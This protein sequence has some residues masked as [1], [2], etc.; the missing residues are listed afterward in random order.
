M[1][2]FG[3][4][5]DTRAVQE[6]PGHRDVKTTMIYTHVL[7]RGPAGLRS[8]RIFCETAGPLMRIN[9]RPRAK[10]MTVAMAF[11]NKES[12]QHVGPKSGACYIVQGL[13]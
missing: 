4:G 1:R 11:E 8:P 12:S 6:L 3:E 7:N 10:Y 13:C 5:S 2:P 9:I